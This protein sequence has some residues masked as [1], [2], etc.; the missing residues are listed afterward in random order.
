MHVVGLR[1]QMPFTC[2]ERYLPGNASALH[3]VRQGDIV[4]PHVELPLAQPQHTAQDIA[5]VDADSHVHVESGRFPDESVTK[6]ENNNND[7]EKVKRIKMTMHCIIEFRML[8]KVV[9]TSKIC[10]DGREGSSVRCC[11]DCSIWLYKGPVVWQLGP[12]VREL[13]WKHANKRSD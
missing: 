11:L 12:Q 9:L 6:D 3:M 4:A 2:N 10:A 13:N 1:S 8:L 5:G 7:K